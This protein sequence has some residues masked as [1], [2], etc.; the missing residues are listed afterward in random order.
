MIPTGFEKLKSNNHF[1]PAITLCMDYGWSVDIV[2]YVWNNCDSS[3]H[4]PVWTM[5]TKKCSLSDDKKLRVT[6]SDS[7]GDNKNMWDDSTFYILS[8][9][10][11]IQKKNK[12]QIY[13]G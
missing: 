12:I 13:L 2:K 4:R 1:Q 8:Y 7:D 3:E 5:T 6:S 10:T 9:S 11:E